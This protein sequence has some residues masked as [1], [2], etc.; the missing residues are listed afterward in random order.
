M[1][2]T[3][4]MLNKFHK[5]IGIGFIIGIFGYGFTT[6]YRIF[7]VFLIVIFSVFTFYRY[8]LWKAEQLDNES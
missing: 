6:K 2:A 8:M 7:F 1:E 4:A 3:E 5:F